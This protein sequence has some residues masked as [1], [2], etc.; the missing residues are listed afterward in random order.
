MEG[1]HSKAV[2]G[3]AKGPVLFCLHESLNKLGFTVNASFDPSGNLCG[4]VAG[5]PEFLQRWVQSDPM[6]IPD[7][8]PDFTIDYGLDHTI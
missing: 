8:E 7:G 3:G 5:T 4:I 1:S 6:R 2:T